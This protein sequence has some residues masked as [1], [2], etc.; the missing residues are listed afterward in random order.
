MIEW[1]ICK[2]NIKHFNV[3][4]KITWPWWC[5]SDWFM[6]QMGLLVLPLASLLI[7]IPSCCWLIWHQ[8]NIEVFLGFIVA[9]SICRYFQ[10]SSK[11]LPSRIPQYQNQIPLSTLQ[12]YSQY[13]SIFWRPLVQSGKK[14]K[15]VHCNAAFYKPGK[16]N[17][18]AIP[19]RYPKSK[20]M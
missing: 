15:S 2:D 7:C 11:A 1:D 9:H 10:I 3:W 13:T 8:N 4:F 14:I 12:Q 19:Q 18:Y 17:T 16:N 6:M 20:K 5:Y